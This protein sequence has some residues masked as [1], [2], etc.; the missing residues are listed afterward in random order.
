MK[1]KSLR[2]LPAGFIAISMIISQACTVIPA[3]EPNLARA[4]EKVAMRKTGS[5]Q[6]NIPPAAGSDAS[7]NSRK[8]SLSEAKKKLGTNLL[9]LID[10]NYLLPDESGDEVI[11]R[12]K[13]LKQYFGK[14]DAVGA[15]SKSRSGQT[16]GNLVKAYVSLESSVPTSI[17]D[18]YAW[19]ITSR[20]EE[21]HLAV[22]L[23]EIGNL[24]SM[25]SLSG[26]KSIKEVTPPR[27]NRGSVT[28][29]GDAI[30]N[31]DDIRSAYAQQGAGVKIGVIS[32]GVDHIS[33]AKATGDLPSSVS[34]LD[35]SYGGDEGTAMLE[36]I[37]DMAPG[38][39]LYFHEGGMDLLE[40]NH[41][42]DDLIAAGCKVIVDDLGWDNE[43]FFEDGVV[44]NHLSSLLSSKNIVLISAA[45]NE[46]DRHYQGTF[47]DDGNGS[48]DFSRGT[49]STSK[50]LYATLAP[51]DWF[52]VVLQWDDV[53]G[54]S[55]NDYDL[56]LYKKGTTTKLAESTD[57]Q[58]G[59]D[60]PYEWIDYTNNTSATQ[61]VQV[62]VNRYSGS[63]AKLLE[64][65]LWSAG[66]S[67]L[68]TNIT[69]ADSV[70]G[71]PNVKGVMAVA[72]I[73]SQ[74][75][76]WD[77]IEEFSSRGP[78]VYRTETRNKPDITGIDN[79]SVSGAGE[80]DSPF[81]G[82]SA[83][84]PGIAAI[85]AQLWGAFPTLAGNT[86]RNAVLVSA[87]DLGTSGFDYT[88]GY[89]RADA[90]KAYQL[91]SD[92]TAE[93]SEKTITSF[94]LK[95]VSGTINEINHT[96]SVLLPAGTSVTSL[97]PTIAVSE[98]ATISPVSGASRSFSSPVTYTVTA[99]DGSTQTYTV[100]VT[101]EEE[102][103]SAKNITSF[104]LKGVA[105]TISQTARTIKVTLPAGTSVTALAPNIAISVGAT[106]SPTS[107][108]SRNFTNPVTYTVTAEDGSTQTYTVTV[109]VPTTLSSA[110]SITAFLLKGQGGVINETA[111][112]ITVNLPAGTGVTSLAP[113]ISISPKATVS[114]ASGV[115]RNFSSPVNYTITAEDASTRTYTARAVVTNAE[116][117]LSSAKNITNFIL[118]GVTGTINETT[119]TIKV[120]FPAGTNVTALS[121]DIYLSPM[122]TVS[123]ASG[124]AK[125]FTNPISYRVTAEDGTYQTYSV[126]AVVAA[127]DNGN[128]TGTVTYDIT[129][130]T[131]SDV[132]ATLHL[133]EPVIMTSDG[134]KYHTFTQNGSW[135]FTYHDAD[136]N[137]G[138]TIAKVTNIDKTAPTISL[139]GSSAM[140]LAAGSSYT[141]EGAT[142]TDNMDGSVS[143]L[144]TGAVNGNVAGAY[145]I[146]YT[147]TDDAGN[148]A[149]VKRTVT[150]SGSDSTDINNIDDTTSPNIRITSFKFESFTPDVVGIIDNS[151]HKIA[152]TVPYGTNVTALVPT[153]LLTEGA[154]VSP[155]SGKAQNF[156]VPKTY[157]VTTADGTK[158]AY[159]VSVKIDAS[160]E[161]TV[162][163]T[164]SAMTITSAQKGVLIRNLSD[165]NK[166]QAEIP[167]G[168]V[169]SDTIFTIK[170]ENLAATDKPDV[171][172]AKLLLGL[173]FNIEAIDTDDVNLENLEDSMTVTMTVPNL[174]KNTAG[175]KVYYYDEVHK[176]WAQVTSVTF[177]DNTITFLADYLATFA[178]FQ[179]KIFL[180]TGI[181]D[182]DIIQCKNSAN[183]YAVY[184]VKIIGDNA[185][186]R[187][188]VSL[189]IFNYYKHLKWE[190]L[191]QVGSL[192]SF[193]LSGWVR[194]NTGANG[195]A[196]S[197]DKVWEINGDQT[198]HWINMTASQFL[199]HGGSDEAI[200]AV[201]QGELNLYATGPDVMS[202]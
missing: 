199:T 84:A 198:K 153:I 146:T 25:A 11:S 144:A 177:G 119:N 115:S 116:E 182:G 176:N 162:T 172:G 26:V 43:P 102:L 75:P 135:T 187:H 104:T 86:I 62:K 93:S 8:A 147:A 56:A 127:V 28:A 6:D 20:S 100:T 63:S 70:Y 160:K 108:A 143:V 148:T 73:D 76:G 109:T 35:N 193:S 132:V 175:L 180:P 94:V 95:G 83:A 124:E 195:Q 170:Q 181:V 46:A 82:T 106:V 19:E 33:Q 154:T 22:A 126:T 158:Q 44:G 103:S 5:V 168:S 50:Y 91:L 194:V 58:N 65:Y 66:D 169:T 105:G 10:S 101:V 1:R 192:D 79:I 178:V 156:A 18:P 122:A 37:Y 202:L 117:T 129:T 130:P 27:V 136:G 97:V 92:Y 34:V 74:D 9:K 61:T 55:G 14:T 42:Y 151:T 23:V 166:V 49:S 51:G 24:E 112:T 110:K 99:E 145:T 171:V 141:E 123:P 53:F 72:A 39:Q 185:Y 111:S 41:A 69:A 38:A 54:S 45:G 85:V 157:T 77:T 3:L 81:S 138:S 200:Y 139:K 150:V 80:F 121:P 15:H 125:N 167:K 155:A 2:K 96:I 134:G 71:H 17:I 40:F 191:K 59:N 52:Y 21:D 137:T 183:P 114:P 64:L 128:P 36:I 89:G 184:I 201:N 186:I 140:T 159:A 78:T 87:T 189:Q 196:R 48:H 7:V 179:T 16:H 164:N 88:F 98:G 31:T 142:A 188:I 197:G 47:Y 163:V 149:T 4:N 190:N 152:L 118:G 32:D 60:D 90:A 131:N 68:S 29:E 67:V 120:N 174:P 173:A 30:H 107:G 161:D 133:S 13:K 113:D 57:T 12:M 165:D